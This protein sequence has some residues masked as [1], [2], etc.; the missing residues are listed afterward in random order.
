MSSA[1]RESRRVFAP[2]DVSV[3]EARWFVRRALEQWGALD[4][5]D[6][7]V[8]ATSELVTNAVVH[9]G[10]P[11]QVRIA[12]DDFALRLEVHDLYP[13]RTLAPRVS[14][15]PDEEEHGRGLL[16][17]AS[18]ASSW[19][20]EYTGSSKHVWIQLART[21]APRPTPSAEAGGEG[22]PLVAVV[23]ISAAGQV[24]S[25]ND[26][27]QR[28]LG[29]TPGELVGAD[30]D[31]WVDS[32]LSERLTAEERWEGEL[33]LRTKDGGLVQAFATGH[34]VRDRDG[35]VLLIVPATQRDLLYHASATPALPSWP[36]ETDPAGLRDDALA[37]L[38]L[39]DF[40][41]LAVERCRSQVGVDATYLLLAR[42]DDSDLEVNA[43]SG[44]DAALRGRRLARD[45]P[46]TLNQANPS[47]PNIEGNL[48][49]NPVPLLSGTALRS[50]HVTPVLVDGRPVGALGAATERPGDLDESQVA[51]L[52]QI[53][54][55]I[56]TA[57]DR[58]RLRLAELERRHWLGLLDEAGVLL[59]G[60]LD[61]TMTMAMTAQIVVPQ[62]APWC[63]IHLRDERG[64]PVL[65]HVWH[66]DERQLDSLR[67]AL[68]AAGPD[69]LDT[70]EDDILRRS[71]QTVPLI[72]RGREIGTL[73]LGRPATAPLNGEIRNV[74]ESI[75]RRAAMA[76]D[77]ARA[78][79]E[80]KATGEALQQSLLPPS[81]PDPPGLDVGVIY[82]PAGESATAGGD[83]YDLFALG[84]GRWCWTVGDVCGTGPEAAAITG[85]ARHTIRALT[86][87]GVPISTTLERLNAAILDEGERGRFL[88]LVC[89]T[90]DPGHKGQAGLSL[91]IAGHPPPFLVRD[92]EARQVGHP[93]L[94]LGVQ[95]QVAFTED[96][97]QIG[98]GDLLVTVTD[99]VLDVRNGTRMLGEENFEEELVNVANLPAQ[100]VAERLRRLVL[101][102]VSG[103][104]RDD[105]AILALQL[106][107]ADRES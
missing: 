62:L 56:A 76:I 18:I 60:S 3:G 73:T 8:L 98:R 82:E 92:G 105:M 66:E 23:A 69:R 36:V 54:A 70:S 20:V 29:W 5:I 6:S 28:M 68:N 86:L 94:L 41:A 2:A 103:P 89:G 85:L 80:L 44:L 90:I 75:A 24:L 7:A 19:G 53:A 48:I 14:V 13:G 11:L 12:L 38:D 58:A 35:S 79:G 61:Q 91:V 42:D 57:T 25:W 72:A 22:E 27:A 59:A 9:A 71:P 46:G 81:I 107:P 16:I 43:V 34:P 88:T 45:D 49:D 15:V 17:T 21:Q 83:F 102:F 33:T 84:D 78:H 77:N 104:H 93:Q 96:H 1:S 74:A 4:L 39:D 100:M 32:P 101:D 95:E 26:D 50:L 52:H 47:L 10:T 65:A 99:G 97:L 30:W 37:R 87:L 64:N 63:A 31:R 67:A 51:V 55:S 106:S 40:L